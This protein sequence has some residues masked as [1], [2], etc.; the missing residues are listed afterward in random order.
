MYTNGAKGGG[1]CW[2][3]RVRRKKCDNRKPVCDVCAALLI[4]CHNGE[5]KPDWIDGGEKQQRMVAALKDEVKEKAPCRRSLAYASQRAAAEHLSDPLPA[6]ADVD[7]EMD[8]KMLLDPQVVGSSE[9]HVDGT[10]LDP[11]S[12]D[13]ALQSDANWIPIKDPH[14]TTN[15]AGLNRGFIVSYLDYYFPFMFPFY[16]PSIL[17]CGRG[18]IIDFIAE[19]RAMEQTTLGLSSYFFSLMLETTES[20][21]EACKRIA[22]EKLLKQIHCTFRFLQQELG[23][24]TTM[25]EPQV[26]HHY[27]A[28]IV[29]LLGSVLLLQRFETMVKSYENCQAHL[30]A[31]V[32][33]FRRLLAAAEP[34]GGKASLCTAARFES[35]VRR[36]RFRPPPRPT[37]FQRHQAPSSEQM[38]FRFFAALLLVDD[39]VAS[40]AL[41]QEPVLYEFHDGILGSDQW[42]ASEGEDRA[43]VRLD[44]MMG[45][46][47]WAMVA[48][49]KISALDAWKKRQRRAGDLDV[50][51][52][53]LRAASIKSLLM[54]NL[55]RAES[56]PHRVPDT[57]D[58][59]MNLFIPFKD[60]SS[61]ATT[62]SLLATRIWAHAAAIYLA[63]VVSGWQ[64]N[65]FEIRHHVASIISLLSQRKLSTAVLR[66]V[67]WPYCIAGCLADATQ[68]ASLR[69]VVQDLRPP[70]LLGP[71][72]KGLEIMESV[73]RKR[74]VLDSAWDVAA[75]FRSPGHLILLT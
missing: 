74:D 60:E 48:V 28:R 65:S 10:L 49:G 59:P 6:G 31:A 66:T 22:W 72:L 35:M 1:G 67:A 45:C 62:Q 43:L 13:L 24:L 42:P 5:Q 41:E 15:W 2:T 55:R 32:E 73:W 40:T 8:G 23:D 33:L 61:A 4:T 26:D 3:C 63:V 50:M 29:H 64:P 54:A 53:A 37:G 19:S 36:L 56:E 30:S 9:H 52:L 27:L 25:A 70:G 38:A 51:D 7:M 11:S 44:A 69:G 16:Q 58:V 12:R 57:S 68:E 75:C 18:W 21:H 20:G 14:Q 47:N 71:L 46:H 39:I 34:T 17:D